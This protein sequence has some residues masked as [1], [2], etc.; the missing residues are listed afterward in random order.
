M[1]VTFTKLYFEYEEITNITIDLIYKIH[2]IKMDAE[3]ILL[4]FNTEFVWNYFYTW[5]TLYLSNFGN[6]YYEFP[7]YIPVFGVSKIML[8]VSVFELNLN[9]Y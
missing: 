1:I 4:W 8:P 7:P 5:A 3:S 9:N 2:N 6:T